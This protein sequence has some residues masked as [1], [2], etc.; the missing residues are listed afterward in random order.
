LVFSQ[1]VLLS[2]IQGGLTRDAAYGVV[3]R[4][5]MA[6]WEQGRSF[7]S[8]LED[9]PEVTL[10]KATLDEAFDLWRS[11]RHID[12]VFAALSEVATPA[13]LEDRRQAR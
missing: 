11:L 2:L 3:Q 7:R 5:A 8:V 9:D 10:D 1:P 6:S 4:D 12:R 13:Q